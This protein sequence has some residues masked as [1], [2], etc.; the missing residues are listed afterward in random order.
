MK[1]INSK[2][3]GSMG[4]SRVGI[5]GSKDGGTGSSPSVNCYQGVGSRWRNHERGFRVFVNHLG[6]GNGCIGTERANDKVKP[7]SYS[8]LSSLVCR[9]EIARRI[10][11]SP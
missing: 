3:R 7:V 11:N 8:L 9:F 4:L 10:I 2:T 6:H 1:G 5:A